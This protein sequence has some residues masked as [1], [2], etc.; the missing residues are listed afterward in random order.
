MTSVVRFVLSRETS[1]SP[2]RP[3]LFSEQHRLL[4]AVPPTIYL[5]PENRGAWLQA[6]DGGQAEPEVSDDPDRAGIG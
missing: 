4:F 1:L 2:S 6:L 5:L 3:L